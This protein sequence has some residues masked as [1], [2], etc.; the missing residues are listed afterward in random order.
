MLFVGIVAGQ[1][2]SVHPAQSDPTRIEIAVEL[3]PG[4]PSNEKSVAKIG[5]A[6]LMTEP[7][8]LIST[9]S[10]A[11]NRISPGNTIPSEDSFLRI[12]IPL[13][14]SRINNEL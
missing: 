7:A 9:G 12:L 4:T 13:L 2:T 3:K 1:I 14:L 5:S 8:L 11:A 10:N 6:G